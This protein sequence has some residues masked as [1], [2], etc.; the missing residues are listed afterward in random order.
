MTTPMT[1]KV[2]NPNTSVLIVDDNPQ[3]ADLLRR[4][5]SGGFGYRNITVVHDTEE[6]FRLIGGDPE[7]F[8]LMFVDYRFP[9]QQTGGELLT[10]LKA[11][12]FMKE[13]VAFLITS[14]P[15]VENQKQA[16][17]A[18]AAG[19]VAKPFD[20]E[21]LRLQIAKAERDEKL[22]NVDSF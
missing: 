15:T 2:T 14:E 6:A 9:E 10:R 12:G 17:K 19:V 1:F 16:Q 7:K 13:R 8:Q 4:I 11:C 18:G 5:L 22:D 20:R 21:K 3:Y